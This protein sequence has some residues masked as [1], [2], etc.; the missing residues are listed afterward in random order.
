[1]TYDVEII[2]DVAAMT[3]LSDAWWDL[4]SR[5]PVATP[6]QSPAWLLPWW[7]AFAPGELLVVAV[8]QDGR[9]AALAPLYVEDGRRALPI[10]IS[11]SD[12][13][14][15]IIAPDHAGEAAARL[16]DAVLRTMPAW[17]MEELHPG[18][19]AWSIP[20]PAGLH[21]SIGDASLCPVLPLP[22]SD[23][24]LG[25]AVP[26]SKLR[27]LRMAENR[28]ARRAGYLVEP[29]DRDDVA[30]FIADLRRLH[31]A[32]WNARG[33]DG[34]L[35]DAAVERFQDEAAPALAQA[36]LARFYRL[37]LEGRVVG[38]FYGLSHRDWA[39]A[40]LGGFDPDFAFE[41]PGTVLTGRAIADAVV[42]GRREF[43][44]LRGAEAYKYAWGAMDRPNRR[45]AI[46][47]CA[48]D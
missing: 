19:R 11:L 6:F 35:A 20:D 39:Y 32:R 48:N 38:A 15:V 5:D 18:A 33:Q 23:R 22:H 9:L 28:C 14:D 31:G 43:H 8:R 2:R 10:G 1:M 24:P 27:K 29:V 42:E 46:R 25:G 13:C 34:L 41:S 40:Y 36:G 21:S 47:A 26:A 37:H 7:R 17:D 45:R 30:G 16:A 44:F 3:R 12:Y 4:W